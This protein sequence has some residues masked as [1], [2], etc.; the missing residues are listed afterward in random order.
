MPTQRTTFLGRNFFPKEDI[1][2]G[3]A[4]WPQVLIR[5]S[6]HYR[7]HKEELVENAENVSKNLIHANDADSENK[8]TWN[9]KLIVIATEKLCQ[10]HDDKFGGF[11]S[12]PKFP[13]SM[14]VDFLL[15]VLESQYIRNTKS[16]QSRINH[17][18]EK[19]MDQMAMGGIFD[20]LDG[21]FFRYSRDENWSVPH[22]EKMILENSLLVSCF[23]RAFRKY[24]SL[25]I[26]KLFQK[27]SNGYWIRLAMRKLVS[28]LR[29]LQSRKGKRVNSIFG[30]KE[31]SKKF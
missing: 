8:E 15:S 29:F 16:I 14:K 23:S 22:F 13:A 9:G 27:P 28:P 4:P 26:K 18:V 12:A 21:G 2:Q 11:S 24:K 30:P 6:E 20:H 19:T 10:L 5:I 17:C 25:C 1:G 3:I 31:N 7:N